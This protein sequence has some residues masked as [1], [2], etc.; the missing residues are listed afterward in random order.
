MLKGS[1]PVAVYE[2]SLHNISKD[3]C[4]RL[5]WPH[6]M[7]II[8]YPCNWTHIAWYWYEKAEWIYL[9]L[10][11]AN[12]ILAGFSGAKFVPQ[13]SRMRSRVSRWSRAVCT[14]T[15]IEAW[16]EDLF[17]PDFCSQSSMKLTQLFWQSSGLMINVASKSISLNTRLSGGCLL[18]RFA[19]RGL[20]SAG[21]Q[22]TKIWNSNYPIIIIQIKLN[23]IMS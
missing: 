18:S 5:Y 21:K 12:S 13:V 20:T 23:K 17:Y 4:F 19:R 8:C 15:T 7:F 16:H 9:F 14:N 3:I 22:F 11:R 10:P 2:V 6:C 1:L